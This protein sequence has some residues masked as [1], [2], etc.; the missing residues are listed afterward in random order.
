MARSRAQVFRGTGFQQSR[1]ER[2]FG[3]RQRIRDFKHAVTQAPEKR[4]LA[5]KVLPWRRRKAKRVAEERARTLEQVQNYERHEANRAEIRRAH[6][7]AW[8]GI[9]TF[10]ERRRLSAIK[11]VVDVEYDHPQRRRI[12]REMRIARWQAEDEKYGAI[13]A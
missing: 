8:R 5:E 9:H 7:R 2:A 12:E 1:R 6:R 3:D 13:A 10:A 4:T 11:T